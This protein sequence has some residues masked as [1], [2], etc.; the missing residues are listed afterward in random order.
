MIFL[1][2][3]FYIH[4]KF[5][6]KFSL[7]I[8]KGER[9]AIFGPVGA[10]KSTLINLIAGFLYANSGKILINKIDYTQS[11]PYDRPISTIFQENNLFYHLNI[12]NN[13]SLGL[14][15]NLK[16]SNK[17]KENIKNIAE[18]LNLGNYLYYFPEQLSVGQRQIVAIARCLLRKKSI[19]LLDE[20]FSSIDLFLKEKIINLLK[21]FCDKNKITLIIILH[22]FEDAIKI[23][24]RSLFIKKGKILWD[25]KTIHLLK[26]KKIFF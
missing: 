16:I 8:K 18:Q 4:N 12:I 22:N 14:N 13:I 7:K 11:Y 1:N 15:Q 2:N 26:N 24:K 9:I 25:G 21:V 17:E 23:T 10:G 6:M 19:L 5:S 20:P 3:I